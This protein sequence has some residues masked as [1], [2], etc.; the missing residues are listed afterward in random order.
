MPTPEQIVDG[1]RDIANRWVPLAILWHGY[2]GLGLLALGLGNRPGRKGAGV[3]LGIPLLSVSALAWASGNPFNGT[4]L[5]MAGIVLLA[6]AVG[7]EGAV[8]IAPAWSVV[9]GGVLFTFGWVYPHFLDTSSL[10]PY[11]YAAPT[12]LIPCP[13]LS[14]VTGL[15]LIIGG[16]GSRAWCWAVGAM[17][18]FYGFFGAARL[19]VMIDWVLFAGAIVLVLTDFS[20]RLRTH[21]IPITR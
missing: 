19:G 11:S 9:A 14:I 20:R 12:G 15:S 10:L 2:F 17:G 21:P 7:L 5:A 3:F 1:L 18:I 13:T 16:L 6:I 4:L 8:K